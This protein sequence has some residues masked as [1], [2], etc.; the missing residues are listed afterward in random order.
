MQLIRSGLAAGEGYS[1]VSEYTGLAGIAHVYLH[2]YESLA[3]LSAGQPGQSPELL[4][5]L[6]A[7]QER[8]LSKAA[9]MAEVA[10]ASPQVGDRPMTYS[11]VFCV[12][13]K[14]LTDRMR[15]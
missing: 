2:L 13:L 7:S 4:Q 11:K 1:G 8:L 14:V 6:V 3:A 9:E 10:R 5:N 15:L 12:V